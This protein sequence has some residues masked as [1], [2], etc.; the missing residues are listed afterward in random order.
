MVCVVKLN[1]HNICQK[2][3]KVGFPSNK[4]KITLQKLLADNEEM[5]FFGQKRQPT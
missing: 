2:Y 3:V 4:V 1:M 5:I